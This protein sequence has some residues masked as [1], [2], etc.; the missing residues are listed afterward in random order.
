MKT[1]NGV[2]TGN[3]AYNSLRDSILSGKLK[4]G[5]RIPEQG[6]A[7][8]LGLSRTPVKEAL[9]QLAN[10]GLVEIVPNR[11]TQVAVY[12][13]EATAK[14]GVVRL[15]FD[16]MIARFV[17]YYGSIADYNRLE[18]IARECI[19]AAER[20]DI[21]ERVEKDAMFHL[22]LV[23]CSRNIY[24]YEMQKNLGVKVEFINASKSF[25]KEEYL[26]LCEYHLDLVKSFYARDTKKTDEIIIEHFYMFYGLDKYYSKEFFYLNN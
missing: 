19:E 23:K 5:D 18:K 1:K 10:E 16:L 8:Q 7:E 12:G 4:P 14:I 17:M 21:Q 26:K 15:F 20:E 13:E 9:N 22:E 11:Y 6:L 3:I 24:L 2:S 25:T